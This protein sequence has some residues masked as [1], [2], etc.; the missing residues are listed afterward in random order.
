MNKGSIRKK[1]KKKTLT[2]VEKFYIANHLDVDPEEL[3]VATKI[4]LDLIKK[5]IE[6]LSSQKEETINKKVVDD[7][8]PKMATAEDLFI[9]NK[10]YGAI[11]MTPGSSQIGDE[12]RKNAKINT[13]KKQQE[14]VTKIKK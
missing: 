5:E 10:R 1:V 8:S 9:R 12:S 7:G 13:E 6:S 3:S 14:Y 2:K 4:P 11:V